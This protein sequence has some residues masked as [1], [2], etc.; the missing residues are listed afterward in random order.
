MDEE[1]YYSNHASN[2]S[3]ADY[4]RMNYTDDRFSN[5]YGG[6]KSQQNEA[7]NGGIGNRQ[8]KPHD[9]GIKLKRCPSYLLGKPL[10]DY[11]CSDDHQVGI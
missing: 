3:H 9:T 7:R 10:M 1:H 6:G 4:D 8:R 2:S 11:D 5:T